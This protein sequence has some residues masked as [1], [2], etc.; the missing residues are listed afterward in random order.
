MNRE[1][2]KKLLPVMQAFAEGKDVQFKHLMG[3]S[4]VDIEDTN[5]TAAPE[6]Y[7]IKPEVKDVKCWLLVIKESNG[8]PCVMPFRTKESAENYLTVCSNASQYEI[9]EM[10]G[11]YEV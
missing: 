2:I 6:K 10:N 8:F 9:V 7:R 4:W 11:S 1:R 5:F 3:D